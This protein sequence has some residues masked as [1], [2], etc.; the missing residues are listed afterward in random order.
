MYD[1]KKTRSTTMEQPPR[2]SR[3]DFWNYVIHAVDHPQEINP[4]D[5][6]FVVLFSPASKRELQKSYGAVIPSL[7]A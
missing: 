6:N 4:L 5:K 1:T 7:C 2:S 3:A